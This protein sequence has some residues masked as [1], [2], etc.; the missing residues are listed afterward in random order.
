VQSEEHVDFEVERE[1][2]GTY[3][4]EDGTKLMIRLI[5][6]DV[7]K[8]G[9]D[10]I[11]PKLK[12][13]GTAVFRVISPSE[14]KEKVKGKPEPTGPVSLEEPGWEYV[15]VKEEIKPT[16][17]IYRLN[18]YL[19]E[20]KLEVIGVARNLNYRDPAGNPIYNV[21]WSFIAKP[22]KVA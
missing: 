22:K 12:V 9:E 10:V 17:S 20:V 3:L 15:G 4:L 14:L 13:G 6:T 7:I 21:R 16:R 18:D 1:E 11:G 8:L 5:V 2:W 19:L